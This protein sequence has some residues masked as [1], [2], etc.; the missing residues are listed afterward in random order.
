MSP[1]ATRRAFLAHGSRALLAASGLPL[2]S[3]AQDDRRSTEPANAPAWQSVIAD[4]EKQIPGLMAEAKLPGLSIAVIWDGKL[5]WR[6]GFGV[7]DAVSK[8]PIDDDTVFNVGSM[9]KPVFAYAVMK[10]CETGVLDLD[11]PLTKYTAA[12]YLE[13][14]PRLDLITTR[15]VLSHTCGFQNWRSA[16]EP[17]K[18]HFTPGERFLYS[19]EGYNYLQSVVTHLRGHVDANACTKYEDGLTVCATDI[20]AYMRTNVFAPF[21]MASA[22]YVWSERL[23]Q[24]GARAHDAEGT[25]LPPGKPTAA[26]AARYAAA[27]L[28]HTT[29]ADFARFM[30]EVIDPQ[31]GDAF[32]LRRE[33]VAEM[34]RPHVKVEDEFASSWALGWQVQQSGVINHGGDNTGF[35]AHAV[36]SAQKKSG[37]V[38][39]TNGEGGGGVL[40]K[41]LLGDVMPRLL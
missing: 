21:G 23:E 22:G 25:R 6:R 28:L 35:H 11:A 9:S 36:M 17:L 30:I 19:G 32:R 24:H 29:P 27:G 10:L 20:E 34:L 18:I 13:G 41:L 7:R 3:C 16:K 12:R 5:A 1:T 15:H 39:M 37:F 33:S 14:D 8:E 2:A 4:L 38:I 26:D 40:L 31:E